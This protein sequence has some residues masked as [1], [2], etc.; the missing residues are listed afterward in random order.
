MARIVKKLKLVQ[1]IARNF[2]VK[3]LYITVA[4]LEIGAKNQKK[5]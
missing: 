1:D 4:F 3:S 5:L 2:G